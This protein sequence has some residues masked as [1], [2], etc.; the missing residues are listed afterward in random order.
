MD[1]IKIWLIYSFTFLGLQGLSDLKRIQDSDSGFWRD[2]KDNKESIR[3]SKGLQ[4][5]P[6]S[7][8]NY[9]LSRDLI[10]DYEEHSCPAKF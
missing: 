7:T 10:K 8:K 2:A 5:L 3:A 1:V 4:G 9:K 6:V